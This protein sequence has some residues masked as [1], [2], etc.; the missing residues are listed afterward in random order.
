MSKNR[1]RYNV[2]VATDQ[3]G[4]EMN[5]EAI[6]NTSAETQEGQQPA[7]TSQSTEQTTQD[8]SVSEQSVEHVEELAKYNSKFVTFAHVAVGELAADI[9]KQNKE[10][11][12]VHKVSTPSPDKKVSHQSSTQ[13]PEGF[14]PVFKIE[15]DLNIYAEA[16]AKT[17]A[18]NPEEG[19]RWQY[20]LF[21]TIK[22]ILNAPD[23][24]TF[25]KEWNT[26][27]NY[28]NKNKDGIFNENFIFRFPQ[29]WPG[30]P[31]EF[32]MHRRIVYTLIQT[33]NP[34]TR[35]KTIAEINMSMVTEGMTEKQ[36]NHLNAFYNV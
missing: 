28:F 14:T 27:L 29:N 22:S 31:Q 6:D 7:E 26:V 21:N 30:S 4:T 32:T 24:E 3:K 25:N 15:L 18:I 13:K 35:N 5:Q 12:V 9:F 20:S 16:M 1:N 23:Q 2:S 8:T 33:A 34:K 17:K 36:R 10:T 19:G 11:Q